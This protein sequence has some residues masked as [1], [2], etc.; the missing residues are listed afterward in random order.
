M[1]DKFN[2]F[3]ITIGPKSRNDMG[4]ENQHEYH[5]YLKHSILT[6]FRFELVDNEGFK[7]NTGFLA[8]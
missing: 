1:A 3:F 5:K 8:R 4:Q 6:S 2:K 7:K